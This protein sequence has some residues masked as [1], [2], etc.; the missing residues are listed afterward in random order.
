MH[1]DIVADMN[2]VAEAVR[3]VPFEWPT[4]D[5]SMMS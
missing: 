1:G 4:G 3:C 5:E 2:V